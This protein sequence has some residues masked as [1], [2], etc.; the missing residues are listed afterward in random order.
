M[1]FQDITILDQDLEIREHCW[2][3]IKDGWIDYI[4]KEEPKSPWKYAQRYDGRERLLMSGFF[5]SH[6]HTP[7]TLMR[8]YGENMELQS[9]LQ[10]RIFPFEE[11]LQGKDVYWASMLGFAESLQNG[12]VSTTDMYF[13]GN[14]LAQ[15][16]ADCGIKDNL[17]VGIT[18]FT[19]QDVWDLERFAEGKQVFSHWNGREDG[20]IRVDM[21]IHAEYTSTPKIVRQLADYTREIGAHM[22]VHVAETSSE[23]QACKERH[24]GKTPVRY[25]YDLGV[26]D[27]PTTAAHCVWLEEED[28][29][30]LKEKNVTVASCPISNLKLG[31][32]V[33]NGAE[34]LKRDINLALGT[35]SVA[36]NNS[37]DFLEEIKV[38]SLIHKGVNQDPTLITP[39]QALYAATAAGA[40]GQGRT[41]TGALAVGKRADLIVLDLSRPHMKPVHQLLNQIVYSACGRD[42]VLTM[43]NGR[44]L[45]R[46]GVF[47]TIDVEQAVWQAEQ[48]KKRIL[49]EL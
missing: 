41:D 34:L 31:S 43:V 16:A 30:L 20:R 37:L 46:D 24:Q 4:G 13:F 12:I 47:P 28:F 14:E 7:M 29:D 49:K 15:A 48:A 3:G 33:C 26:F 35:D 9:W 27:S 19:D 2:V 25:L 5:N 11:K 36:S 44:T 10:D 32:G 8:G 6:A 18:C 45:Y 21:S 38:F 17:S 23:Q 40:A 22:H 42:V 39:K 1:L